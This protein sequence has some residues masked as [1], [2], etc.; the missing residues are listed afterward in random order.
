[1]LQIN[2]CYPK[3]RWTNYSPH[4]NYAVPGRNFVAI[5]TVIPADISMLKRDAK[6]EG[7]VCAPTR[8]GVERFGFPGPESRA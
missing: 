4:Q 8:L 1:M 3:R 2:G 7:T 6:T 5:C